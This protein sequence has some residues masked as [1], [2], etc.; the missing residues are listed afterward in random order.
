MVL[1]ES[2]NRTIKAE[3]SQ[4][5]FL[6]VFVSR[7]KLLKMAAINT[8]NRFLSPTMLLIVYVLDVDS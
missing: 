8:Q 5:G 6:F 1:F 3:G 2:A 4:L 7:L